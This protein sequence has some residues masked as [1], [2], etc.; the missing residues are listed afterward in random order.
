MD[1]F[2]VFN[3]DL[4][5]N[6]KSMVAYHVLYWMCAQMSE[7]NIVSI[8]PSIRQ[9]MCNDLGI[10]TNQV[11]N[12]LRILKDLNLITGEKGRYEVNPQAFWK[13]SLESRAERLARD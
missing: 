8:P 12:A 13:G 4:L 11:T 2:K 6:L 5:Y 1:S 10:S 7:T 3:S 9:Q